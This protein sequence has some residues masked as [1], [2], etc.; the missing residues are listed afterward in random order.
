MTVTAAGFTFLLD[1]RDFAA[2]RELTIAPDD[3]PAGESGEAKKSNQTHKTLTRTAMNPSV[4]EQVLYPEIVRL[5][6]RP[7]T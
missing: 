6:G 1:V 7:L 5:S 4:L 2:R 3:A